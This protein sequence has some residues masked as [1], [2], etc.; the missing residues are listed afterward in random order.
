MSKRE[1]ERPLLK[2]FTLKKCYVKISETD[3]TV[4]FTHETQINTVQPY[5]T[6]RER[7]REKYNPKAIIKD[8][9]KYLKDTMNL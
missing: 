1:R 6:H 8:I 3:R 9:D 2:V 4:C 5:A 7:E